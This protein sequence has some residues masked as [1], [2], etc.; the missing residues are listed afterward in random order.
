MD[1]DTAQAKFF[2]PSLMQRGMM[3]EHESRFYLCLGS[4]PGIMYE[5]WTPN[6]QIRQMFHMPRQFFVCPNW[7]KALEMVELPY[8]F[9]GPLPPFKENESAVPKKDSKRRDVDPLGVHDSVCA[10]CVKL[11][12]SLG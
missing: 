3:M 10:L 6:I 11:Q 5:T 7:S 2:V 8:K 9:V 1:F 4:T 12:Q